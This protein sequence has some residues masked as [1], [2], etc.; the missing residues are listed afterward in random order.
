MN[1]IGALAGT[2]GLAINNLTNN[3]SAN[4]TFFIQGRTHQNLNS[5]KLLDDDLQPNQTFNQ[6]VSFNLP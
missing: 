2:S 5:H 3:H 6:D 1:M 4:N